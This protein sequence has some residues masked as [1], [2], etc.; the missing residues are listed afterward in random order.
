MA[1]A[2]A[3][4]AAPAEERAERRLAVPRSYLV[5]AGVLLA[6][7]IVQTLNRQWSLDWYLHAATV[8]EL[9]AHP[10]SPHHPLILTNDPDPDLSPYLL[11][12]GLVVRVTHLDAVWVLSLAGIVNLLAFLVVLPMFVSGFTK[13]RQ[14]ATWTLVFALVLWGV[15]P[16]RWSGYLNLNS[17]G[18]GLP[19]PSMAATVLVLVM[20]TLLQ[21]WCRRPSR[22]LAILIGVIAATMALIHP[23]TAIMGVV[24]GGAI[25][26]SERPR[27][28]VKEVA[29][30]TVAGLIAFLLVALWPLYSFFS[31]LGN[32]GVYD[33]E[34]AGIYNSV[35][36][37]VILLMLTAPALWLRWKKNRTDALVLLVI[38]GAVLFGFGA[39]SGHSSFGRTLPLTALAAQIALADLVSERVAAGERRI[40]YAA[41]AV[42]TVG[43]LLS[44]PVLPRF[45][46]RVALPSSIASGSDLSAT[47]DGW[48]FL[49]VIPMNDVVAV[50]RQ[51]ARVALPAFGGKTVS[52]GYPAAFVDDQDQRRQDELEIFA[53]K[54]P[55]ERNRL[56]DK[57]NV[58]WLLLNRNF[59]QDPAN[60]PIMALGDVVHRDRS[61]V[62]LRLHAD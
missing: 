20:L 44:A 21:H 52:P 37:R 29:Q 55:A 33:V 62:L 36:P 41:G 17:I 50:Q 57:Y 3:T 16:W 56:L 2:G 14:A 32:S 26:F 48:N 61:Y 10:F 24:G 9:A 23:P 11:A 15:N 51:D 7:L 12:L 45:V 59:T 30:L 40:G 53:T 13:Q 5:I 28:R 47:T 58:R 39:F 54:D 1:R 31:L 38:G 46:P 25:L 6:V 19:Y 60:R 22:A 43:L 27:L 49:D 4:M 35:L 8:R 34:N 18:F 42:A